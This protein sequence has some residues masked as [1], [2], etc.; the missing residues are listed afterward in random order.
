MSKSVSF[1]PYR[2]N[3]CKMQ[4]ALVYMEGGC[5]PT[6]DCDKKKSLQSTY[7]HTWM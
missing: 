2:Y 4:H 1:Q 7:P 5:K 6:T 3:P